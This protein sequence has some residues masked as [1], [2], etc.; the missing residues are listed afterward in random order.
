MDAVVTDDERA[1]M[2]EHIVMTATV[3]FAKAFHRMLETGA[4]L[5]AFD[6]MRADG[7]DV[8]LLLV[9]RPKAELDAT[10]ARL[11]LPLTESN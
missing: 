5:H 1:K 4:S 6:V 3:D 10:M 11:G 7:V 9:L 2:V 8:S